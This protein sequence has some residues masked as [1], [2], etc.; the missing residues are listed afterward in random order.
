MK[1]NLSKVI[2]VANAVSNPKEAIGLSLNMLA[3]KN[4]EMAKTLSNMIK[5][6]NDPVKALQ[7]F[8]SEGKIS[9]EDLAKIKGIYG[10]AKKAGFKKFDIPASVWNQA[11]QALKSNSS[12]P[13]KNEWF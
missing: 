1:F 4:P 8:A 7:K 12:A 6:G 5:S 13:Q 2:S 11:E 9:S 10:M 3:K